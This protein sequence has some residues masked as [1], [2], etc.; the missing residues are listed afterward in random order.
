MYFLI[1]INF[2]E[3]IGRYA[4]DIEIADA[5]THLQRGNFEEQAPRLIAT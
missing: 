2:S 1:P 4:R 3:G 5:W